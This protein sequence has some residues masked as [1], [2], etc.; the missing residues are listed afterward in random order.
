ME[1]FLNWS[2]RGRLAAALLVAVAAPALEV[3]AGTEIQLRLTSKVSSGAAKPG[4]PVEAV[5]V[6][7]VAV[8]G[9]FAMPAGAIVRGSVSEARPAAADERAVLLLDFSTIQWGERKL[10]LEATVVHVDNARESVDQ[11]GRIV[12]ILASE[13]ISARLDQAIGKVAERYAGLAD[14]LD[15]A[16]RAVMSAPD[17]EIVAEPGVELA[18]RLDHPLVVGN[19]GGPGPASRLEPF[20]AQSELIELAA[21]QPFQTMAEKPPRPSDLTNL[22]FLGSEDAL[23]AAFAAAGW[24][25]AAQ[26]NAESKLE[27]FRAIVELR[28]YKEAPVSILLLE[29]KPPD[30]VFQKQYNTFALRHHLRIWRRPGDFQGQPVW[31]CAA[32]HDIGIDFSPEDRTFIHRIDPQIDRER[33]KVVNDL[34]LT[35]M[36]RSLALVER[37]QVPR[38]SSNATGDRLET[39]GRMAVLWIE[40]PSPPAGGAPEPAPR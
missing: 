15:A 22:M 37:P 13:T 7:P 4:Q 23:S 9:R 14:V 35:G 29:G 2:K 28:G 24:S 27:T 32:T 31:V 12:G 10:A 18:L 5:L 39:D 30:L 1:R 16:R 38:Q 25:S 36:V 21:R 26:L 11:Q 3:P 34:L 33:A 19:E 8:E 6:A 17:V 20:P 40:K